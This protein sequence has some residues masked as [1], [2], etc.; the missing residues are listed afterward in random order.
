[1]ARYTPNKPASVTPD[2]VVDLLSPMN[3]PPKPVRQF[4]TAPNTALSGQRTSPEVNSLGRLRQAPPPA[5]DD[6]LL[7]NT[8]GKAVETFDDS[9]IHNVA[10]R[11]ETR[12]LSIESDTASV[13]T[14]NGVNSGLSMKRAVMPPSDDFDAI[15]VIPSSSK[16]LSCGDELLLASV[17]YHTIRIEPSPAVT[18]DYRKSARRSRGYEVDGPY[19][20]RLKS[21]GSVDNELEHLRDTSQSAEP[22]RSSS[23]PLLNTDAD[24]G[25]LSLNTVMLM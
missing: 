20:G 6:R 18:L 8:G 22:T 10:Y 15:T 7:V 2:F 1:M 19:A 5:D 25:L 23:T 17:P 11:P 16:P 24:G 21:T 9:C 14:S 13:E 3:P 12:S 4:V